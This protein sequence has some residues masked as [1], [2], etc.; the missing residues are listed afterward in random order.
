MARDLTSGPTPELDG[1]LTAIERLLE[2][3]PEE[4]LE[5]ARA[6]AKWIVKDLLRRHHG[7]SAGEGRY[8][9]LLARL[10][11]SVPRGIRAQLQ[12]ISSFRVT[13]PAT[14]EDPISS[15]DA[16]PCLSS[17]ELLIRWY[18]E[19]L[20]A[21]SPDR[22]NWRSGSTNEPV[23]PAAESLYTP[24]SSHSPQ[25]R[26]QGLT[27]SWPT[28]SARGPSPI[29]RS[30]RAR[31]GTLTF[32][33]VMVLGLFASQLVTNLTAAKRRV[34]VVLQDDEVGNVVI[35]AVGSGSPAE[36]AGLAV[37]DHVLRLDDR[38]LGGLLDFVITN[39]QA[40]AGEPITL[41]IRRQDEL[42]EL[43][44]V[45]GM[46][47]EWTLPLVSGFSMLACLVLGIRV[48]FRRRLDLRS[49]L[50][51]TMLWL[52]AFELALPELVV[53]RWLDTI[54]W[55]SRLLLSG[56]QMGVDFNLAAVI[57]E[58]Q[59]WIA[60]RPWIIGM[61]YGV[62]AVIWTAAAASYLLDDLVPPGILPWDYS[63][64]DT[65]VNH[66]VLPA[67][68]F[69]VLG[70][71][72]YPALRHPTADGRIQARTVMLAYVPWTLY[73][74]TVTVASL[75]QI[76]LARW[77]D[78]LF[79]L[80]MLCFPLAVWVVMELEAKKKRGI[81]LGLVRQIRRSHS[82]EELSTYVARDLDAAFHPKS[83][84]IFFKH[85]DH[86]GLT[87]AHSSD[88]ATAHSVSTIAPELLA[89]LERR[90]GA[91][92]VPDDLPPDLPAEELA[93]LDAATARVL[94]P[95]RDSE[96]QLIGLLSIGDKRSE[97]IYNGQDL[98]VLVSLASQIALA[99]Q[100]MGLQNRL[101]AQSKIQR[102]VLD[103][104]SDRHLDLV[105]E[106]PTCGRCFDHHQLRCPDD[107]QELTLSVPVERT[108]RGRYRLERT[109]GKGGIGSV[110]AA[111]DLRL[112]RRVAVKVL[113]GSALDDPMVRRRFEREARIVAQL[114]HP[115]IVTL[116]DCGETSVG[117]VFI[118]LELLEGYTLRSALRQK[119]RLEP[120]TAALCFDQVLYA[121]MAA[122]AEG[123]VHR[124]LKPGNVYVATHRKN[125]V[126]K[127]LD[128]GIAKI[129]S[130]PMTSGLTIPGVVLGTHGY[131][132]PEQLLG[133]EVDERAD[134]Y[135]VGVMVLEAI[136][137]QAPRRGSRA[138]DEYG[139]F[140]V[141]SLEVEGIPET[142]ALA[143]VLSRC[144][145]RR[146][147]DR[148]ASAEELRDELIPALRAYPSSDVLARYTHL[149][150]TEGTEK[151]ELTGDLG[152]GVDELRRQL[153]RRREARS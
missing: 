27:T 67:W 145:A 46:P 151:I 146:P 2:H 65:L 139:A 148:P 36:R 15:A 80:L 64:V 72:G 73:V 31:A 128:F 140:A 91:N 63:V 38:R 87:P 132:A 41:E 7:D 116:Y 74:V 11:N 70:L 115:N 89:H 104:F 111:T 33:A 121:L 130:T 3:D 94:V 35:V 42:L 102:E 21:A 13:S 101:D 96:N 152:E 39:E 22:E 77:L 52:Q 45:P 106:C 136:T 20:D 119:G 108:V 124:D 133:D 68:A 25:I 109:L 86:D 123:I 54:L 16:R 14:G 126:V 122:H 30:Y 114:T 44:I 131:M 6:A 135:S 153:Q 120:E 144:L 10:G 58:R 93:W 5:R 125:R 76:D 84:H 57:P 142:Q 8:A 75:R 9:E 110:Y 1:H 40:E 69:S 81:L 138:L 103:R 29:R 18:R 37:G 24:S 149:P 50:L 47:V 59:R 71:L 17:L 129:K 23:P 82:V 117:N 32:L 99:C 90:G 66:W 19:D 61:F 12:A 150:P 137:G 98:E 53:A 85:E 4:A 26:G 105:K 141:S 143:R 112:D 83:L 51:G 62:A 127:L 43:A 56:A 147:E 28:T 97:E 134:L 100:N 118:V 60:R 113:L 88:P 79:P 92:T 95:L 78:P 34:G 107:G 55:T 49:R 48:L